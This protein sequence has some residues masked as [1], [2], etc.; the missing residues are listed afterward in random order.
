MSK[1]AYT[2]DFCRAQAAKMEMHY[3]LEGRYEPY[4]YERDKWLAMAE[5][6]EEE[7]KQEAIR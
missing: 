1:Y 2:A 7:E 6:I 3:Y 5:E 4:L